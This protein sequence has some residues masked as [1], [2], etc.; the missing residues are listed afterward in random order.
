MSSRGASSRLRARR[1]ARS[2][3]GCSSACMHL[4][5]TRRDS[6]LALA[7]LFTILLT[8]APARHENIEFLT[9][10]LYAYE[11]CCFACERAPAHANLLCVLKVTQAQLRALQ[12]NVRTS[13]GDHHFSRLILATDLK[14]ALGF[15]DVDS[16]ARMS[17]GLTIT[18][19]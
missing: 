8:G 4:R 19:S 18:V 15:M 11:I 7:T 14:A 9:T 2:V 16:Q 6:V 5:A 13:R 10:E 12:V 3:C 17:L 1:D